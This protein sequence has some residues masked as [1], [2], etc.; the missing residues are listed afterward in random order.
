MWRGVSDDL[1]A[2]LHHDRILHPVPDLGRDEPLRLLAIGLHHEL[3]ER[4]H[5]HLGETAELAVD[6][7]G[8]EPE[9]GQPLLDPRHVVAL[10]TPGPSVPLS[11]GTLTIGT[12]GLDRHHRRRLADRRR[13]DGD[14]RAVDGRARCGGDPGARAP[15]PTTPAMITAPRIAAAA[16][17]GTQRGMWCEGWEENDGQ[18]CSRDDLAGEA[19]DYQRDAPDGPAD[20]ALRP[21]VSRPRQRSR[22]QLLD[23]LQLL[24][25]LRTS[26][27]RSCRSRPAS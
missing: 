4:P 2:R 3:L 5:G 11:S 24:A 16:P 18:S 13:V 20:R 10:V 25:Q 7:A 17:A 15:P 1:A 6:G 23:A 8:G 14:G 27:A 12:D 9:L 22:R 19:P 26:R 21:A